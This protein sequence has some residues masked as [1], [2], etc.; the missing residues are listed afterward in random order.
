MS[1]LLIYARTTPFQS[2]HLQGPF[3]AKLRQCFA[4]LIQSIFFTPETALRWTCQSASWT[5]AMSNLL[6]VCQAD[7]F[8][9]VGRASPMSLLLISC[10]EEYFFSV[11]LPANSLLVTK[12][13][14]EAPVWDHYR[15]SS[16]KIVRYPF[17]ISEGTSGKY[18]VSLA[19]VNY[20]HFLYRARYVFGGVG[21]ER[22]ARHARSWLHSF[23]CIA[24]PSV[25][26]WR[27][28]TH[29]RT[30]HTANQKEFEY[31]PHSLFSYS[32]RLFETFSACMRGRQCN[33]H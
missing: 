3:L 1:T 32:Q 11:D 21:P 27:V 28:E 14:T 17:Q 30:E 23:G 5:S 15:S 13:N 19:L 6:L 4:I 18:R 16:E 25:S 33:V 7:F 22:C 29:R 9:K 24:M 10:Q 26:F 31:Q 2:I 8:E 20:S 12:R